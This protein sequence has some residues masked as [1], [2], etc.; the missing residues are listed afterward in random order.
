M[1]R[2]L[3][4]AS[5]VRVFRPR[6]SVSSTA[7]SSHIL[8]RCSTRRIAASL[9]I[10]G[11]TVVDCLQ[12]AR[13][14]VSAGHCPRGCPTRRWGHSCFRP[15]GVGGDQVWAHKGRPAS[16][17]SRA[18]AAGRHSA[19]VVGGASRCPPR[20]L[21]LQPVLRVV[22]RLGG[23]AV[24]NHAVLGMSAAGQAGESGECGRSLYLVTPLRNEDNL[25]RAEPTII[26]A[27]RTG[28]AYDGR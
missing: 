5:V 3:S 14:P 28:W 11:T 23:A 1:P 15:Q 21:R 10:G 7:H 9:S 16:D 17:P 12:R 24:A 6:S 19:T 25:G 26:R 2:R 18:D 20:G 4:R 27:P 13:A 8:I 22:S